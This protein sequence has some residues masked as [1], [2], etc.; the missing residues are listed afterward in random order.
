MAI[1]RQ[2]AANQMVLGE[3]ASNT[4]ISYVPQQ[5][6][7]RKGFRSRTP[8]FDGYLSS[9]PTAE[10]EDGH[11]TNQQGMH[12]LLNTIT[13]RFGQ[14]S[15]HQTLHALGQVSS[16]APTVHGHFGFQDS[17]HDMEETVNSASNYL[18]GKHI[19]R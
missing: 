14:F 4:D 5:E 12:G 1:R 7:Q 3:R 17:L 16:T 11:Y 13:S 15:A 10:G 8:N 2:V 18:Q 19:F 6:M 9:Q